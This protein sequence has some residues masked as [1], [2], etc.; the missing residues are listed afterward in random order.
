MKN[1]IKVHWQTMLWSGLIIL[2]LL[3][4]SGGIW[5]YF[6]GVNNRAVAILAK[7][8]PYPVV[9]I[10]G[11]QSI[12]VGQLSVDLS[13]V[14][15]FYEN[16]DFSQTGLRVDFSTS[17]GQK[18]LKIKEKSVL[19]KLIENKVIKRLAE[20][21]GIKITNQMVDQEVN[22]KIEQFGN[23]EEVLANLSKLYG[24]SLADFER[25]IVQPDLYREALV[26]YVRENDESN[27]NAKK[28]SENAKKEL[29]NRADFSEV[30]KKYSQGASAKDG[31]ELGWL[32]SGQMM[33]EISQVAFSLKVGEISDIISTSLGYHIIQLEERKSEDGVD[34]VRIRQVFIPIKNFSDWLNQEERKLSFLVIS[35]DFYWDKETQS[36]EFRQSNMRNFESNL[37][38]NSNGD[39][40][41]LFN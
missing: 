22:Q 41:M 12:S 36:I 15:R 16:Q 18:R 4:L 20:E 24:W 30:A 28:I 5:I 32:T 31:G 8:F 39:A 10:G 27:V 38:K 40:S 13:S 19:N 11:S 34:K 3:V 37:Q 23:K 25:N 7:I 35:R 2:A 6:L 26:K 21:R 17:D 1:E 9:I 14:K 29:D 33:P